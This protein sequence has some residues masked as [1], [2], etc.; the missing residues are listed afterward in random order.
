MWSLLICAVKNSSTRF[1]AFGVGANSGAGSTAGAEKGISAVVIRAYW[2]SS[3]AGKSSYP[4]Y[5]T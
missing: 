1:A 5:I 4:A 3:G 2:K